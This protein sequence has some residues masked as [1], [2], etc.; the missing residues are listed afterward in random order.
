[1]NL[2]FYDRG[3]LPHADHPG[4]LQGITYR[5]AD[6][7]PQAVLDGLRLELRC[8]PTH[9]RTL[10]KR[11]R[12]EALMDSGLG[13]CLLRRPEAATCVIE[14]WRE[15]D[16]ERYDLIAWVVMPN[17]VHVLIREYEG[18]AL[19]SVVQSWKSFTGRKLNLLSGSR[20]RIWSREYWDRFIRDPAHFDAS[21]RYI[22]HNPVAAG[23]VDRPE[24]WPWSSARNP[25]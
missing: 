18:Y 8:L 15:F 20:G 24:D 5:L 13:S 21:V 25:L 11:A 6:S 9:R 10:E 19:G 17:H 1:V 22:E 14:A 16:G 7:L 12:L 4:L 2:G 23:L 3:Y